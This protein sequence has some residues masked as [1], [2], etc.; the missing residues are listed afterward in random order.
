MA[1]VFLENI[2]KVFDNKVIAV[3]DLTLE[4]PDKGLVSLLGP[5]GC[6]KTTTMRIIAGLESPT[7][8]RVFFD[9]NDMTDVLPE[10]RDVAMV[11]QFP[12]IYP[13]MN[14]YEN[15]AFPLIL[16]VL[17]LDRSSGRNLIVVELRVRHERRF[18]LFPAHL[19]GHCLAAF[20]GVHN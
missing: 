1:R 5:S 17:L 13:G 16:A 2:R 12:V 7:R 8:G 18:V 4:V 20:G 15:I 14:V 9:E 19:S 6:G 11:F 3:D 10:A